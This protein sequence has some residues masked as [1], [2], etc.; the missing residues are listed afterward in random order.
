MDDFALAEAYREKQLP[1][2]C[3]GGKGIIS[4]RMY[5]EGSKQL[6]EGWTKNFATASASTHWL[7]MLFINLWMCGGFAATTGLLLSFLQP[8]LW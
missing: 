5:P 7:V 6:T 8:K 3:Y 4:F 1:V 2:F